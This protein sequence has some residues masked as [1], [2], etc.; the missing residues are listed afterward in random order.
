M[1]TTRSEVAVRQ[2]AQAPVQAA[3]PSSDVRRLRAA[4][5]VEGSTLLALVFVAVPLKHLGGWSAA[6]A[7]LGPVHG[8]AFLFYALSVIEAVAGGGWTRREAARL[9]VT[10]FVPFGGFANLP[11]LRRK[12]AARPRP[13]IGLA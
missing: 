11:L 6:V 10:A 1:G 7:V 2:P 9:L 4:S 12:A 5:L 13:G 8:L 3:T